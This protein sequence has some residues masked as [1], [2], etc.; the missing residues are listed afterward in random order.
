M[1]LFTPIGFFSAVVRKSEPSHVKVRARHRDH[2]ENLVEYMHK[3]GKICDFKL[4]PEE[5]T[6]YDTPDR[7]YCCRIFVPRD[8]WAETCA[9]FAD[10]IEYPNFKGEVGQ[11]D[12]PEGF[13]LALHQVWSVLYSFQDAHSRD[14]PEEDEFDRLSRAELKS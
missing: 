13:M 7:D 9:Q 8:V 11:H 1:W 12:H 5:T 6:I 14:A 10:E 4:D 2:L 3:V